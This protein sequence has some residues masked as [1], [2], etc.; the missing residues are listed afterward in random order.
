MRGFLLFYVN[1]QYFNK[2]GLHS[3]EEVSDHTRNQILFWVRAVT[4]R[5]ETNFNVRDILNILFLI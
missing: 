5:L 4:E 2:K 1:I 3:R